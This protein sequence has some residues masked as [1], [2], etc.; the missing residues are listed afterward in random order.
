[1]IDLLLLLLRPALWC[2]DG[3]VW[4]RWVYMW[5]IVVVA[6]LVDIWIAHTTWR[7]IAGKPHKGE[8]TISDT[9]ERLVLEEGD[10]QV[11]YIWLALHINRVSPHGRHIKNVRLVTNKGVFAYNLASTKG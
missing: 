6:W 2:A 7:L 10:N 3:G 5:P 9:L 1:M 8:W 11:F 4:H